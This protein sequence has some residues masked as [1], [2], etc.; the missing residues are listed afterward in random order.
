ME[1]QEII[2][3]KKLNRLQRK[4][5]YSKEEISIRV[6]ILKENFKCFLFENKI[7]GHY[8]RLRGQKRKILIG[9]QLEIFCRR[10]GKAIKRIE[11]KKGRFVL[12]TNLPEDG[13]MSAKEIL[14]AYRG[15]NKNI[16]S[17]FKFMKDKTYR[18][19]TISQTRPER[20]GA[21][22]PV[23]SLILFLNNL[24]QMDIREEL[25]RK[26][27]TVPDQLGKQIENPTLKWVFQL[28]RKI[29]K[30]RIKI[31]GKMYEQFQG[32]GDTQKVII[33]SLGIHAKEIYGFP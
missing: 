18:L 25:K 1:K 27:N 30:V 17:C 24:G 5:F 10:N 29:T 14:N 16:E 12:A 2:I 33:E 19:S 22:M 9:Y 6:E 20:I 32:I 23:I 21:M 7:E 26:N 13:G 15:Q 11:N 28:L 3:Q 4:I 31:A 8:K